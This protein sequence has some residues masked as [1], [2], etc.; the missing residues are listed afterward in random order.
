MDRTHVVYR[1]LDV[2]GAL[3]YVGY[4]SNLRKRCINHKC[5]MG[6]WTDVAQVTATRPT[7]RAAAIRYERMTIRTE[8]PTVNT[9]H[10]AN[11]APCCL[12]LLGSGD[13][14]HPDRNV[15][16]RGVVRL[17]GSADSPT[18]NRVEAD[19]FQTDCLRLCALIE[20][21]S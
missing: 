15:P 8:Q 7:T 1:C 17:P 6:W 13:T 3:I 21:E 14:A 18:A 9:L 10:K 4:T 19:N 2:S 5:R 12:V 11:H 20:D 16:G